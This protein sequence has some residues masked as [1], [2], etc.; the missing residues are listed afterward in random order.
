MARAF[1]GHRDPAIIAGKATICDRAE[2]LGAVLRGLERMRIA[3]LAVYGPGECHQGTG[4]TMQRA[5]EF[6]RQLAET[7]R[8]TRGER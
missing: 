8:E 7:G 1:V 4:V 5:A 2:C 6:Y 3:G